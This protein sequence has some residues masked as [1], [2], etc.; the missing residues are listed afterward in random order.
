MI[1]RAAYNQF[2]PQS[3]T[4][5][6][7]TLGLLRNS[8]FMF[9]GIIDFAQ[10]EYRKLNLAKHDGHSMRVKMLACRHSCHVLSM[11]LQI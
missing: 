11:K 1:Y 6:V 8:V 4:T 9:L 5:I 3:L 7:D 2:L 10:C